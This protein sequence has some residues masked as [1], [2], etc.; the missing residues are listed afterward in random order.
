MKEINGGKG[1]TR[2]DKEDE[3]DIQETT[4]RKRMKSY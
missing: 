2:G 3:E 4:K 1:I